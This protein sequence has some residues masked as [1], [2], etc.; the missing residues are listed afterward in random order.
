MLD[1]WQTG[2]ADLMKWFVRMLIGRLLP[3]ISRLAVL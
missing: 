1:R 2:S 3:E